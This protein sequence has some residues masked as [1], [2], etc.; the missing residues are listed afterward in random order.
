MFTQKKELS[1]IFEHRM[2]KKNRRYSESLLPVPILL[3]QHFWVAAPRECA[4]SRMNNTVYTTGVG[5]TRS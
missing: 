2:L 4:C 3:A 5:Q 1:S